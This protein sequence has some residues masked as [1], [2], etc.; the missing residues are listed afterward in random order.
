[1]AL[2]G[3][4]LVTQQLGFLSAAG[5]V[6]AL[7]GMVLGRAVRQQLSEEVFRKVFFWGLLA[8]GTYIIVNAGLV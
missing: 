3:N 2:Q 7:A 8:L 4:N 5:L 1:M 6:P